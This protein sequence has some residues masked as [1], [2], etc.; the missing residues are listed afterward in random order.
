MIE[1]EKQNASGGGKVDIW[2]ITKSVKRDV[3]LCNSCQK[4]DHF[5]SECQSKN[6]INSVHEKKPKGIHYI[7]LSASELDSKFSN[8]TKTVE[9]KNC[10]KLIVKEIS[11]S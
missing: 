7:D 2:Q 11:L 10:P 5:V 9:K 6:K 4:V 8:N 1:I 3:L